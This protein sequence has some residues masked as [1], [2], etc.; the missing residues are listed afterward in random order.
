[1]FVELIAT[2]VAGIA[3]AGLV[4]LINRALGGR[5]PKWLAPVMAGVA[6]LATTISSEYG[7][8]ERTRETL[9]EG[10]VVAQTVENRSFYRPWTFALPYVERFVAIDTLSIKTHDA[11]PGMKLADA[12]YFGRWSTVNKLPVLT[13][14]TETRRAALIDAVTFENSGTID[15]IQWVQV[16]ESDPMVSTICGVG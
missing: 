5:M 1:M 4:M 2:I 3:A 11:Q 9:P 12:Y 15:G 14:C 7:W 6:M 13:D 8:Y 10:L 16:P